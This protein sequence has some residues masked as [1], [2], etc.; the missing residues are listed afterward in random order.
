MNL[1]YLKKYELT[2]DDIQE[3]YLKYPK[4]ILLLLDE[5]KIDKFA[6]VLNRL[7][8]YCIDD[9][10]LR[11]IEIFVLEENDFIN[12]I[13]NLIHKLGDNYVEKINYDLEVL[14]ELI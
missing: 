13:T 14:E 1:E 5:R 10:L 4:E 2:D 11:F 6:Q 8:I 3:I 12:K 7:E 9:I